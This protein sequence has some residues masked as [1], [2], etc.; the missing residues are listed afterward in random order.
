MSIR[1]H[2]KNIDLNPESERYIHKKFNRIQRRL[3]NMGDGKLEVSRVSDRATSDRFKARMTL[4]VA[5]RTLRGQRGGVNLYAAVDN[6]ADV[7][8]GQIR[9]FKGKLSPS[10]HVRRARRGARGVHDASDAAIF[11]MPERV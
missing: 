4:N 3:P 8:D 9:R 11:E 10:S 5:G 1:I 7:V 6:V 2:T